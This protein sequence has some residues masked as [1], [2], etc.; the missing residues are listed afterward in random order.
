MSVTPEQL[1]DD[2][3][4]QWHDGN[5]FG[6]DL[7]DYLGM[8]KGQ[9]ARWVMQKLPAEELTAWAARKTTELDRSKD[10]AA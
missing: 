5:G 6:I 9:Y 3:I 1:I 7:P 4:D 10:D 2:L 8:T